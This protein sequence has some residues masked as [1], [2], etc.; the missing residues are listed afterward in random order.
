MQMESHGRCL[1]SHT[2]R[3]VSASS[4]LSCVSASVLFTAEQSS[5]V[6]T[7][8]LCSSADPR[9]NIGLSTFS[10][11]EQC[12]SHVF[13]FILIFKKDCIK[14]VFLLMTEVSSPP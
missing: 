13:A 1:P 9:I 2:R 7:D 4:T 10:D 6:W 12:S 11:C 8:Q 14:T 5:T 3:D